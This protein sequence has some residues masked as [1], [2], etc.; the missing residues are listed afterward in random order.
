MSISLQATWIRNSIIRAIRQTAKP[1]V[2]NSIPDNVVYRFPSILS[3]ATFLYQSATMDAAAERLPVS[4]KIH[5]LQTLIE[6]YSAQFPRRRVDSS[7]D[8]SP[9]EGDVVL[10]TGTTGGFGCNILAQLAA[11]DSVSKIYAFNR[12]AQHRPLSVRQQDALDAGGH[13]S[14]ILCLPKVQLVEADLSL[15]GFDISPTL[16][17]EGCYS[18][19]CVDF[20]LSYPFILFRYVLPSLTLFM[21]V[22]YLIVELL[23]V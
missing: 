6:K 13:N 12:P 17:E 5:E 8:A 15:S 18:R 21:L 3:L 16:F 19:C 11:S 10:L 7:L 1:S 23:Y 4:V 20:F 2:A 9:A 22:R 14:S